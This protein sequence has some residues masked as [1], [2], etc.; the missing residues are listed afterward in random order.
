[1]SVVSGLQCVFHP[2]P[3]LTELFIVAFKISYKL[4]HDSCQ[5]LLYDFSTDENV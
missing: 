3:M 2:W 1:M 4:V 5:L